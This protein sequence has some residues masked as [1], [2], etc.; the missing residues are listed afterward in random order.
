M[1][2]KRVFIFAAVNKKQH[3]ARFCYCPIPDIEA[4]C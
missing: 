4:W 3:S 1:I 2:I